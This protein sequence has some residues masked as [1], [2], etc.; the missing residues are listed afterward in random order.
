MKSALQQELLDFNGL[1]FI[2]AI[3]WIILICLTL[4]AVS[5]IILKKRGNT[6]SI[7]G[8]EENKRS[9]KSKGF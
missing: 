6:T 1:P 5:I 4:L 7:Q 2:A 9:N 8:I 3:S